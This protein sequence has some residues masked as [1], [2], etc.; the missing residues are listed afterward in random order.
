MFQLI[1]IF[2]AALF[3]LLLKAKETICLNMIVKNEKDVIVR[4][5]DSVKPLI[6]YWVI[7]DTGSTD[8]TQKVIQAHMQDI[9]GELH[10]RPWKNFGYNRTE[11]L[12]LAKDKAN[13]LLFIDADDWLDFEEEFQ[14]SQ[15]TKDCYTMRRGTKDCSFQYPQ[16]VK[17]S[18]SWKYVGV[19]H[20]HLAC[21]THYSTEK[22][23]KV[24]YVSGEGGAR[25]KNSLQKFLV[26]IQL[27]EEALKEEPNNERYVFYL[28]ESYRDAKKPLLA[29]NAYKK[30]LKMEGWDQETFWA[31][32]QIAHLQRQLKFPLQQVIEGYYQ[33]FCFRP[34]RVE[35]I[36]YLAEIFNSNNNY[37]AAYAM[38]KARQFI[39]NPSEKDIHFYLDWIEDYGLL[40]QLSTSAYY[41]GHYIES[42]NACNA[43][44]NIENLPS[45]WKTLIIKTRFYN[46]EMV[47]SQLKNPKDAT[48]S[49]ANYSCLQSA[50]TCCEK[51]VRQASLPK[52]K[53][54]LLLSI[55]LIQEALEEN[56]EEV[57]RC[58]HEARNELP[59]L[60]EPLYYLTCYYTKLG[61]F[62]EA[63]ETALTALNLPDP[64]DE[65]KLHSWIY[66]YG[67]LS[68]YA[69]CAWRI[70]E[71]QEAS[72]I[73]RKLLEAP[74][75]PDHFRPQLQKNITYYRFGVITL[76]LAKERWGP[77]PWE[78]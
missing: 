11:A 33:A 23:E 22:M 34:H 6:D 18:L 67:M 9:P 13:Y 32:L 45:S 78:K 8:G 64:P 76:D 36:Y 21:D 35:P 5:L 47:V 30:R 41:L 40:F 37:A 19:T 66:D 17:A 50:M 15:L 4:C 61:R 52:Q 26:N 71:F 60:I 48:Q 75:T 74:S 27:L 63:Y 7:V 43:L 58:Y 3:P 54:L 20:E 53:N 73:S 77:P 12:K 29:L 44:L 10:E 46:I 57:V 51:E 56:P 25:S 39:P 31:M 2:I 24:Q 55:A 42:L 62:K 72:D 59:Y 65:A 49:T 14:L 38:L 16:L 70:G 28:A 1:W 69:L 68:E